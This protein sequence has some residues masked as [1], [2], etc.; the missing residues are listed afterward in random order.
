MPVIAIVFLVPIV[1]SVWVYFDAKHIG[2]QKG[3]LKG[4]AN[5]GPVGWFISCLGIWIIAFP[6]YLAM[7]GEL[8]RI[9]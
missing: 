3:Q 6:F 9:N 4:I 5:M 7:R 8:K 2:A 1:T